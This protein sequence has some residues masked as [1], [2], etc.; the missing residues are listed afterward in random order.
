MEKNQL[1]K[2]R[3]DDI[4]RILAIEDENVL[5]IPCNKEKKECPGGGLFRCFLSMCRVLRQNCKDHGELSC[6][7]RAGWEQK[8]NK[9]PETGML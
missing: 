4:V 8:T 9:L 1:L 6:R 5:Y 3:E 2:N 7:M